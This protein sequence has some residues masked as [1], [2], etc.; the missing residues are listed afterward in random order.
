MKQKPAKAFQRVTDAKFAGPRIAELKL[1][2][3][4]KGDDHCNVKVCG[5]I[6]V[7]GGSSEG[8]RGGPPRRYLVDE[9][10]YIRTFGY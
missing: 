6:S 7:T 8:Y 5:G 9:V 3:K 2:L 4:P 10:E 1:A